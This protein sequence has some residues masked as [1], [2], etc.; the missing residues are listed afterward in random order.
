MRTITVVIN[1]LPTFLLFE[2]DNLLISC[3]VLYGSNSSAMYGSCFFL[4][5]MLHSNYTYFL[6]WDKDAPGW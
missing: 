4:C 6:Y 5:V 3:D 1:F 2:N